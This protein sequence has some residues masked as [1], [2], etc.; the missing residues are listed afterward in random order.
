ML[1]Q[2]GTATGAARQIALPD[3]RVVDVL[4]S[5][6]EADYVVDVGGM[7]LYAT[8]PIAKAGFNAGEAVHVSFASTDCL[9]YSEGRLV[10]ALR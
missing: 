10:S 5:G 8:M 1:S 3:G 4:Y 6:G 7:T 9:I 2:P